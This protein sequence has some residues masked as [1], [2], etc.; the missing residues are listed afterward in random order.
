LATGNQLQG[1][2]IGTDPTG[3]VDVGNDEEGINVSNAS[4]NFIGGTASGAGNVISGNNRIG[5][6]IDRANGNTVQGNYVGVDVTGSVAIGN[7]WGVLVEQSSNNLVGGTS[8]GARN[9]ISGNQVRGL[10]IKIDASG[11]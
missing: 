3:T 6:Y 4:N 8:P 7:V 9:V 2:Y 11:N 5:V 10:V 1:N